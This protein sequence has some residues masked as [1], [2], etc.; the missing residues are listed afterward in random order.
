MD[1]DLLAVWLGGLLL[2]ATVASGAATLA[3]ALGFA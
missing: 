1:A 2:V 3:Q